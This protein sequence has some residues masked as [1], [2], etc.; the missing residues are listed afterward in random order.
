MHPFKRRIVITQITQTFSSV[1]RGMNGPAQLTRRHSMLV[2]LYATYG[3]FA[4]IAG[5]HEKT[6]PK[7]I[8]P[9][10]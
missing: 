9:G 7:R 1:C 8:N 2:G 10:G 3:R 5:L 4:E 6:S